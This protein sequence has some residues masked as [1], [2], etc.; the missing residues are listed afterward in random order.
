MS[1]HVP[2]QHASAVQIAERHCSKSS[3]EW[4]RCVYLMEGGWAGLAAIMQ[5][6]LQD[7]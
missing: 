2:E 7:C 1:I 4:S 5:L 3:H 6:N